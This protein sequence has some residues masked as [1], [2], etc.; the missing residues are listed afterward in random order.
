MKSIQ[1]K[2][3]GLLLLRLTNGGLMLFHGINKIKTPMESIHELSEDLS[4]AGL[5][6]FFGYGVHITEFLA[7]ILLI[8]GWRTKIWSGLMAVTMIFA[9]Y[10]VYLDEVF[11]L[12]PETGAWAIETQFY[13]LMGA[14]VLFFTGG[15]RYALSSKH[16]L[17]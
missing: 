14:V 4:A 13:Y 10:A 5:P 3:L 16:W 17:D 1:N 11:M 15:G 12:N 9:I 2:D 6:G 8:I 7:P